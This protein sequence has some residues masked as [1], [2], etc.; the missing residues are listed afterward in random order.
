MA[1]LR[2]CISYINMLSTISIVSLLMHLHYAI[3]MY[4]S[5]SHTH[6]HTHTHT[7]RVYIYIM[8]ILMLPLH[9]Q[10]EHSFG[11]TVDDMIDGLPIITKYSIV[12]NLYNDM[13]NKVNT[14]VIFAFK[15]TK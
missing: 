10:W 1:I 2:I 6:T 7:H 12:K 3:E 15:L 11:N 9:M 5:A 8:C 4:T 13:F 14:T